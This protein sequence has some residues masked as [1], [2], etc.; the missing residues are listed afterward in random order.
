[1]RTLILAV[2]MTVALGLVPNLSADLPAEAPAQ[3]GWHFGVGMQ[4]LTPSTFVIEKDIGIWKFSPSFEFKNLHEVKFEA[5]F[6][7]PVSP[8]FLSVGYSYEKSEIW[9]ISAIPFGIAYYHSFDWFTVKLYAGSE[10]NLNDKTINISS[11]KLTWSI[12]F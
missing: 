8:V 10:L 11:S 9:N 6:L 3:A 2:L 7:Y 1:M 5:D 12:L 4:G